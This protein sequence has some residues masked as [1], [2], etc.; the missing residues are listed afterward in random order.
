[1]RE[2]SRRRKLS[3]ARPRS[4]TSAADSR[5]FSGRGKINGRRTPLAFEIFAVS[6]FGGTREFRSSVLMY[7]ALAEEPAKQTCANGERNPRRCLGICLP[8]SRQI[9]ESGRNDRARNP[10]IFPDI[11]SAEKAGKRRLPFRIF[12]R[13]RLKSRGFLRLLLRVCVKAN[14]TRSVRRRAFR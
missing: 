14:P 6:R 1:M 2:S 9:P 3:D 4:E 11:R 13:K 5:H 12:E 8:S 10:P 7:R